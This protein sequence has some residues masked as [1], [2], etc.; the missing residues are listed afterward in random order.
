MTAIFFTGFPGFL[1]SDL[2]PRVLARSPGARGVCL[3]QPRYSALALE[4]VAEI[5][6]AHPELRGRVDLR[7][8][9]IT[10]RDLG[11]ASSSALR[12]DIAEIYHLAA[13]YDLS[14]SREV[15]MRANVEGTEHVLDFAET[16]G[17]LRRLHYVSTCYVSG[18]YPGVFRE[19]DLECGQSFHNAYEE[20]KYLA[21]V[22][23]R[24]R[25]RRGLPIAI[26]RP[27]VVVGDSTTGATQKYDGPYYAIQWLLRQPRVAV[28]PVIGDPKQFEFNVVP[29]DF[30]VSAID[31]IAAGDDCIGNTYQLA[32]PHPPTVDRVLTTLAEATERVM[33]RI[34]LPMGAAKW[35]IDHV[36]GVYRTLRIPSSAVDYFVHPTRYDTANAAAALAGSGIR[37]PAFESYAR[38]LVAFVK[39][40]PEIS[41]AAMA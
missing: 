7:S 33:I 28:M 35:S 11:I 6:R 13:V 4:R 23:A 16:C 27:S 5:E 18:R 37:C 34:P 30:V 31:H 36:P 41:S 17:S 10:Q 29:R 2:L 1:C 32:D 14:V 24:S 15:G 38:R 20:T 8:G 3:V 12:S 21:E 40:H 39:A 26:Y 25:M 22:V 9:D 19:S